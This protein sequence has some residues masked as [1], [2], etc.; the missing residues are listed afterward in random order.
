MANET[1]TYQAIGADV[2]NRLTPTKIIHS[3][4]SNPLLP[5]KVTVTLQESLE[6]SVAGYGHP[7]SPAAAD[8]MIRKYLEKLA[9]LK[10][11]NYS[12][13]DKEALQQTTI[14][15][16][17]GRDAILRIL[18][19]GGCEGIRFYLA[20]AHDGNGNTLPNTVGL[21]A[22]GVDADT[23]DLG[24]E[25]AKTILAVKTLGHDPYCSD[26]HPPHTGETLKALSAGQVP[27]SWSPEVI[28][29]TNIRPNLAAHEGFAKA[30]LATLGL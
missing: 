8:F 15:L 30:L 3:T 14:C 23:Y 21:V 9:P 17:M 1:V 13:S 27:S 25:G 18:S 19:Q 11:Q 2:D 22:V 10:D 12:G 4:G 5:V 7:A 6:S 29:T 24:T 16:T 20:Q 26:C 28:P